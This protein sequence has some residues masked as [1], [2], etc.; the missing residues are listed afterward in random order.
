MGLFAGPEEYSSDPVVW[1]E[2]NIELPKD[3][4]SPG[5]LR[6]RRW[7]R[8]IVRTMLDPSI[9]QTAAAIG[10]QLG[11]TVLQMAGL[12]YVIVNEPQKI[13]LAL[14]NDELKERFAEEKLE[15]A[16]IAS[17]VVKEK[18]IPTGK[19]TLGKKYI[20]FIGGGLYYA[21]SGSCLLYTSP[22]PRDS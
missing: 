10:T 15:K 6:F 7:Q 17:P 13:L 14:P 8:P 16:L 9:I 2:A 4:A 5:P 19:G 20:R 1:C 18:I 22:S 11:K 12:G 21:I 3:S